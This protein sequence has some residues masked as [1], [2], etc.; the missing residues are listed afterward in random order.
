MLGIFAPLLAVSLLISSLAGAT[1]LRLSTEFSSNKLTLHWNGA[2]GV[3]L[4]Q[5]TSLASPQWQE[6]PN[7]DGLSVMQLPMSNAMAFFRLMGQERPDEG[8]GLDEFTE[9]NGWFIAVDT[10]GYCDPRI[11]ELRHATSDPGLA[12]TDGD[13]IDD[14]WEWILGTDPRAADTDRDGLSDYEELF[15]WHTSPTSADTDGDARGPNHNLPPNSALFDGN[16]VRVLHTSPTLDDT[17]GDGRTDHEE[18][19]QPGRNPLVA[20]VPKVDVQLV[21]AVDVRLDVQYAEETGKTYQYGTELSESTTTSHSFYNENS[22]QASL[23]LGVE[24]TFGIFHSGLKVTAQASVGYG[25]VWSTTDETATT[26]ENSYSQYSTDSRTRTETAASGSMSGGIR[27]VNSGPITYTITDL[28]LAVRYWMP[29]TAGTNGE[30]RTLATLVPVL[31]ANGITLA[32]GDSTPILQV[33]ATG[34]SA[35]RVKEF[36]ARPNSLYLEPAFYELENAQGLNFDFLEEVTRWRTARVEIDYGN[37]TSE[38]Y[39]VATNVGRK[40]DGSYAGV[41]MGNV[42]SNILHIPFRT[43]PRHTLQP[44][45]STNER[46]LFS[47][48]GVVTTS[49][50]NG[51]WIVSRSGD[52]TPQV[53]PNFEDIVLH[54]GDQVLLTFAKDEDGDGLFAAEEQHYR[55]DD[56]ATADTDGDGL[57]DVFEARIGWDAVLPTRPY[58]VYSDPAEA[59]QDGD[60]LTDLQECQMG[61]DPTNPDTDGDGLPDGADPFPTFPAKVLRVKW[62]A[63]GLNHGSSWGNALADLQDA[64]TMARTAATN[65]NPTDDVAEIWVATGVYKPTTTTNDRNAKFVLV[66]NTA[67]YGGFSGVETKLSQR[68]SKPL[69]NGTVLSG[70]LLNNDASTYQENPNSFAEN[71]LN[72]CYVP[73][74]AGPGLLLDG[75]T[76]TGS[77]ST[78]ALA[79]GGVWADGRVQ[80]KNL[81]FRAN[82]S[83]GYGGAIF[84]YYPEGSL[85]ISDCLF[86]QNSAHLG[87]GIYSY[88]PVS[89]TKCLFIQNE[90]S[91]SGGAVLSLGALSVDNCEFSLNLAKGQGGAIG[92]YEAP[93]RISSSRF[94]WNRA[95]T[96]GGGLIASAQHRNQT[97]EVL[98]SVFVG[99]VATTN[100]GGAVETYTESRYTTSL[101]ILNST[102]AQNSSK[103]GGGVDSGDLGATTWI[104]NSIL[105]GNTPTNVVATAGSQGR[106]RTSCLS[107][108]AKYPAAG[109]INADPK[110]VNAAAGDV[111]LQSGSSCID[112]GNNYIDYFPTVPGFQLLPSTDLDG[113]W[114]IVEGNHDGTATVD[115]GAFEFQG[116]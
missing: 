91:S 62:D 24:H 97:I 72:V 105:W 66:E 48:R 15:I 86:L 52:G 93:A 30:F 56:S 23:T 70:D 34:L 87:G 92:Q 83:S 37:G 63:T 114:R 3:I 80:L 17:D 101:H 59:D 8:E 38:G 25:H 81:L 45:D 95:G 88:A 85:L 11:V 76:I 106:V 6:V 42:L 40:E 108:A 35:P 99:N 77:N 110:F 71:S 39:R 55:T 116:Q 112:A 82:R 36:L 74:S 46:V 90:A 100:A 69:F 73:W 75:F 26:A 27:L 54:A 49:A 20:E 78:N 29:G 113:N 51:F 104:E 2:S 109:N 32:P 68:N 10:S 111:R 102:F 16:E 9:T 33:Q 14:F 18:Y 61:T 89:L 53:H 64:L 47:V 98:Q 79:G 67:L 21:D 84:A 22:M 50:T 44:N 65:A 58:H 12:D 43:V 107:E 115:M 4:Q 60:G 103:S 13:G 28:G 7:S 1:E 31:G 41:T 96:Y 5:A 94:L 57:S 19:D